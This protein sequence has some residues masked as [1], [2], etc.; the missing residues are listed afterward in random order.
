VSFAMTGAAKTIGSTAGPNR[1][2][3]STINIDDNFIIQGARLKLNMTYANDPDLE[4]WL[5]A[6]FNDPA[7]GVPMMIRLFTNVGS[8]PVNKANFKDTEFDDNAKSP[9]QNGGAPFFGKFNPQDPLANLIGMPSGGTWTLV[10]KDDVAVA[11]DE[12]P[13]RDADVQI[14]VGRASGPQVEPVYRVDHLPAVHGGSRSPD[15]VAR[16]KLAVMVPSHRALDRAAAVG[17]IGPEQADMTV[18]E[19]AVRVA[20]ERVDPG[21]ERIG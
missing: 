5:V 11:A 6:P 21:G 7:T 10:V 2:T 19:T 9:I 12:P 3:T 20:F 4:A 13:S 8:Q 15:V 16:Q 1:V 17:G 18:D 14:K